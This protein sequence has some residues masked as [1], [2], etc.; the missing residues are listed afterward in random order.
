MSR[1]PF[2]TVSRHK[3]ITSSRRRSVALNPGSS[4]TSYPLKCSPTPRKIG[5]RFP[6]AEFTVLD[7]TIDGYVFRF[8]T[9]LHLNI[10]CTAAVAQPAK[11]LDR[12]AASFEDERWLNGIA[13][14]L[15]DGCFLKLEMAA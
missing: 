2:L 4:V 10:R 12:G 14:N 13:I 11:H 15:I 1:S 5:S 8:G 7:C 3:S 6:G 9:Q